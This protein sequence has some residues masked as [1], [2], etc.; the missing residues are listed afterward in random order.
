MYV[1]TVFKKKHKIV[2]KKVRFYRLLF[3]FL[4]NI[5]IYLLVSLILIYF[6]KISYVPFFNVKFKYLKNAKELSFLFE[7]QN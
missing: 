2:P 3:L 1:P 4:V 5:F 7:T 6:Y